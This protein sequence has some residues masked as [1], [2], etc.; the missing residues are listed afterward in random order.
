MLTAG[1]RGTMFFFA[2]TM[3]ACELHPDLHVETRG[4]VMVT[5]SNHKFAFFNFSSSIPHFCISALHQDHVVF[6][7]W[8]NHWTCPRDIFSGLLLSRPCHHIPNR[9]F[10]LLPFDP[11][12]WTDFFVL[13]FPIHFLAGFV[14]VFYTTTTTTDI[15]FSCT[16]Q[17]FFA[18][19]T[20][21]TVKE[22]HIL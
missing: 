11:N 3:N 6:Q 4:V 7:E 5:K 18:A 2:A 12:L 8:Y 19:N 17:F 20:E 13:Q 15:V 14:G 1:G 10:L 16:S 22:I 9:A 21:V